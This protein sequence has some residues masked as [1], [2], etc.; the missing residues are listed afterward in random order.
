MEQGVM[1]TELG[2]C[3]SVGRSFLKRRTAI[4]YHTI[5]CEKGEGKG[6][7]AA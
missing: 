6:E 1:G 5:Q 2:V 3:N 7:A 4:I